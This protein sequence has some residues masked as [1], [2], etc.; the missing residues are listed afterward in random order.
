MVGFEGQLKK[1][2]S[3]EETEEAFC[4]G[5]DAGPGA[6]LIIFEASSLL[7]LLSSLSRAVDSILRPSIR[8]V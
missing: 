1:E 6:L 4:E 7:P 5:G 8:A 2:G 3:R